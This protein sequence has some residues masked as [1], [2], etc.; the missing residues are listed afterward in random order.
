MHVADMYMPS[1][2]LN[3]VASGMILTLYASAY[4]VHNKMHA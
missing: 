1:T 2:R 3:H 4:N